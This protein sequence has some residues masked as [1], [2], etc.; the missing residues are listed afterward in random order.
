MIRTCPQCKRRV[1]FLK[2]NWLKSCPYCKAPHPSAKVVAAEAG[3]V[4][5]CD[6]NN[7]RYIGLANGLLRYD[8]PCYRDNP[9]IGMKTE[10]FDPLRFKRIGG[11]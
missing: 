10:P 6:D 3:V 2:P 8:G 4:Y 5:F 7:G 9:T 1:T 11:R